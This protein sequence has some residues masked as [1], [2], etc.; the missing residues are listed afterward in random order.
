MASRGDDVGVA[1]WP[2]FYEMMAARVGCML[3]ESE[4]LGRGVGVIRGVAVVSW[5][6]STFRCC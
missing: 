1:G 4:S 3:S 5:V 6:V 2:V